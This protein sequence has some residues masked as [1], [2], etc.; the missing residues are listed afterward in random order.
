MQTCP[1]TWNLKSNN[2]S[3]KIILILII[4]SDF[5]MERT[6]LLLLNSDASRLDVV[7]ELLC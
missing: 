6:G 5:K 1:E 3:C 2:F 4:Q 7:N